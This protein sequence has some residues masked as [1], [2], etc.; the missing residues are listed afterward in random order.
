M[1]PPLLSET[2]LQIVTLVKRLRLQYHK[3]LCQIDFIGQ[4]D[5]A[6]AHRKVF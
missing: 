4:G 1:K 6:A 2:P 3:S 5:M